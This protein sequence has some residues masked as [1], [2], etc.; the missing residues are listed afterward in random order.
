MAGDKSDNKSAQATKSTPPTGG[1]PTKKKAEPAKAEAA[2]DKK[3]AKS[4]SEKGETKPTGGKDL[5]QPKANADAKPAAAKEGDAKPAAA[6][7]G[8]AK[9]AA[10][11]E[12]DAKPAAAK[13]GDAKPKS[14]STDKDPKAEAMSSPTPPSDQTEDEREELLSVGDVDLDQ[15]PNA[16]APPPG[17]APRGDARSFRK[18][19]EFCFIYRTAQYLVQRRGEIGK[20]GKWSVVEYPHKGSAGHAYAEECSTIGAEGFSDFRGD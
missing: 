7:E 16:A 18:G 10:A 19:N 4:T 2:F 1:D 15:D 11:K 14:G 12:G 8:D 20:V 13:E 5:G 17:R 3:K 6:K 9:P